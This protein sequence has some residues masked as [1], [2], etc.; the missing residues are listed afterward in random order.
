MPAPLTPE[1]EVFKL[2]DAID[3]WLDM[4]GKTRETNE[5]TLIWHFK[6]KALFKVENKKGN[7]IGYWRVYEKE[8]S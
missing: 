5:L 6:G 7:I 1:I 3:I 2:N 4:M 8:K